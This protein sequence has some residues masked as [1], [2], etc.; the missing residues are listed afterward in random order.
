MAHDTLHSGG[1]ARRGRTPRRGFTLTEMIIATTMLGLFGASAI[2][3][4][5]R[6]LRSVSNTAGRND[7]QQNA[8]FALDFMDHDLRIAGTGLSPSQPLFIAATNKSLAFNADLITHDTSASAPGTYFDPSVPD[9]VALAWQ[10]PSAQNLNSSS[11]AYPESTFHQAA[12]VI[13]AAETVQ[14]WLTP[15]PTPSAPANRFYLM[16]QVNGN[17][18]SILAK[19]IFYNSSTSVPPFQYYYVDSTNALHQFPIVRFSSG[20]FHRGTPTAQAALDSIREVRITLTGWFT[21][22]H[23]GQ[24]VYRTVNEQIRMPNTYMS[25]IAQCNSPPSP[26]TSF[27][28]IPS[29]TGQDTVGLRWVPSLDDQANKKTVRMYLIYRKKHTDTT[30]VQL[31]S[32]TPQSPLPST[33]TYDDTQSGGALVLGTP[34]DYE[35]VARDCTPALSAAV[36]ATNVTPN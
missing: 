20:I 33:Y 24:N 18:A 10:A 9:S 29:T 16:R 2:T 30:Y 27:S 13:S 11:I 22:P 31:N 6:S 19:N 14:F 17:A 26:V 12:G 36:A 21:D 1:R 4:Y 28:A 34:Y 25:R 35:V 5:L 3:F 8:S 23:N 7:A 15:D 32:V